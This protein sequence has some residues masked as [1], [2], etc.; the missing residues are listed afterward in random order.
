[1]KAARLLETAFSEQMV[2]KAGRLK[3]ETHQCESI[4]TYNLLAPAPDSHVGANSFAQRRQY[5]QMRQ[6]QTPSP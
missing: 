2:A 4:R 1:M 3:S 5:G 6:K